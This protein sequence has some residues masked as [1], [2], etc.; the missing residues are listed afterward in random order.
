[1]WSPDNLGAVHRHGL[2]TPDDGIWDALSG[3]MTVLRALLA[4]S[5]GVVG[6]DVGVCMGVC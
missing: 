2:D 4:A 6:V 3:N 1:M 5:W